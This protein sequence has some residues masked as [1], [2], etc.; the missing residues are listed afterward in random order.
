MDRIDITKLNSQEYDDLL[1]NIS[2][3]GKD[4]TTQKKEDTSGKL[5][6]EQNLAKKVA[7]LDNIY[8]EVP[9]QGM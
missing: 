2:V 4:E 8:S 5:K 3:T 1:N 7:A 6:S 9:N